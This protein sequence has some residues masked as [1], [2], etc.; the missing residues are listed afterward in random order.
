MSLFV[1]DKDRR[2]IPRWRNFRTTADT[3]E[4]DGV[5]V[6]PQMLED[7]GFFGEKIRAWEEAKSV[8][9][10]AELV[11]AAL[12]LGRGGEAAE[13]ARL[14]LSSTSDAT[15]A[16]QSLARTLLR[17]GREA[18]ALDEAGGEAEVREEMLRLRARTLRE[19]L[20]E[21][22]RNAF[23]WV[24]LARVYATLGQAVHAMRAMDRALKLL[25]SNRFVLRSASRLFVHLDEPDRADDMLRRREVTRVDPWVLAAEI[26]VATVAGRS[27]PFV[28]TARQ[29]L[30]SAGRPPSHTAELASAIA[31]LELEAGNL[32]EARRLFRQSLAD[33]NDN[34]V[35]QAG[36]AARRLSGIEVPPKLLEVRRSFE[37]RAFK[38]FYAGWWKGALRNAENWLLDEPFSSRPAVLGSYVAMVAVEDYRL[39]EAFVRRG[40][41]ANRDDPVLLNNLVVALAD[42]GSLREA[43]SVFSKISSPGH[44]RAETALLATEGLLHFRRG[45]LDRGRALYR[46]AMERAEDEAM[47]ARAALHLARE[48]ILAGTGEAEPALRRA[49]V[50]AAGVERPDI[51]QLLD[52]LEGLLK[53]QR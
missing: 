12:V 29:I 36:W 32:R 21:T 52:R 43:E 44:G 16:V 28:K 46:M 2:V 50:E 10:A 30:E 33:P 8:E 35:A 11:A 45:E 15:P 48:E 4:L 3:G 7:G 40:L 26:G 24:D 25:P 31:T 19:Q 20:V 18:E 34:A 17:P 42:Q 22:P 37:A 47:R 13:A 49:G 51:R 38:D 14:I 39:A 41:S 1:S 27:S 6:A 5:R 53:R 23:L 9:T